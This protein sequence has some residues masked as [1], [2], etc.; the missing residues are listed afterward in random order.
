[1]ILL[2]S[3]AKQMDFVTPSPAVPNELQ[4]NCP[5]MEPP[6]SRE[7]SD[8]NSLLKQLEPDK[9]AA[10]MKISP[11]LTDQ[12]H[13]DI[14]TFGTGGTLRR[15]AVFA[16]SGTVFQALDPR[17]LTADQMRFSQ[18]HLII[19]SGLYGALTPFSGIRPYRL[20]MKTP[21]VFPGGETLTSF[22]KPRISDYLRIRLEEDGGFPLLINLSSGEYSRTLDKEVLKDSILNFHFKERS[23]GVLRTVGMYAK[24]AR[25]L[26]TRRILTEQ[27]EDPRSL[28]KGSTGGYRFDGGLSSRTDWVFTR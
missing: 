4:N 12:T 18:R 10:L 16:Y 13:R 19:L 23:G 7:A 15:P 5:E 17:S 28:Q 3:P 26:M 20:E 11:K 2:L 6:F 22:W 24:T 1:M 14:Q 25:G 27:T 8:I 21:L 9:L